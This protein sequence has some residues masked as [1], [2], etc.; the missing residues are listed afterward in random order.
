MGRHQWH[1]SAVCRHG[2]PRG[3]A[4]LG[5]AFYLSQEKYTGP[6]SPPKE[7]A[8]A[9]R[10]QQRELSVRAEHHRARLLIL[11]TI[12]GHERLTPWLRLFVTSTLF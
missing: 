8:M 2:L 11:L 9:L 4:G 3:W 7:C 5:W 12:G 1:S 6:P 10:F